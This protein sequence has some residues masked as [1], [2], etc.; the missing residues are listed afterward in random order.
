MPVLDP[1]D[2]PT[3]LLGLLTCALGVTAAF[4]LLRDATALATVAATGMALVAAT[5]AARSVRRAS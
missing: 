3:V 5:M 2:R 1:A 4:A